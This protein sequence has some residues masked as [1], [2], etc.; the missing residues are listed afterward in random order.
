M[1]QPKCHPIGITP[2]VSKTA[3]T[4]RKNG[5]FVH[6]DSL[7]SRHKLNFTSFFWRGPDRRYLPTSTGLAERGAAALIRR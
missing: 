3:L 6:F 5:A 1:H 2:K 7:L 4:S